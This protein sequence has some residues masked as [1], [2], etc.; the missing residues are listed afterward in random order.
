MNHFFRFSCAT[1][2]ALGCLAGIRAQG[3]AD[4]GALG[5]FQGHQDVGT[6]SHA[7]SVDYNAANGSYKVTGGGSNMWFANDSFHYVWRKVSEDESLTADIA[8]I[9]TGGDPHR[10]ACLVIRQSLDA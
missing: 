7:G 9:G 1:L 2:Y 10:K 5:I 3:Q 4:A 8:F 6:P